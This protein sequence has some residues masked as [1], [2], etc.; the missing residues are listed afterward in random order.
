MQLLKTKKHYES[1]KVF[2]PGHT[3]YVCR[4]S[5]VPQEQDE[6]YETVGKKQK[7]GAE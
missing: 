3:A 7:P 5:S 1:D 6:R 2:R 4:T